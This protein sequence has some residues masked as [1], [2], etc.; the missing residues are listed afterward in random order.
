[1]EEYS[2]LQNR[3]KKKKQDMIRQH[4]KSFN[5]AIQ[6]NSNEKNIFNLFIYITERKIV[7]NQYKIYPITHNLYADKALS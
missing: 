3:M 6:L 2:K 5:Y 4:V 1:M 7:I